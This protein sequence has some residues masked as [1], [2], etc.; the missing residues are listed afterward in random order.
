MADFT[1]SEPTS[2]PLVES[3]SAE[4]KKIA[5][6]VERQILSYGP[7]LMLVCVRFEKGAVGALHHHPHRQATYVVAGSFD[8]SVGETQRTLREGDA[9]FAAA[10]IP[11]AV[12]ALEKG[13]LI[14]CFTPARLDFLGESPR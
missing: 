9:F 6:G 8:V 5:D 7:D 4:W 3:G 10:D 14:D 12:V 1:S 11:H 2:G 13:M